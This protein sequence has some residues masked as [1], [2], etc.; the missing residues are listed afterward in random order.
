MAAWYYVACLLAICGIAA[1]A[2]PLDDFSNNLA[3]DLGPLLALFGEEATKQFLSESTTIWDNLNFAAAPIGILTAIVSAIRVCGPSWLRSFIGR[4]REGPEVAEV[5]LCSSTGRDVCEMYQNGVIMR[6]FGRP[7]LLEI[8][9]DPMADD[10]LTAGIYTFSEYR[11]TERGSTEWREQLPRNR[12]S[13]SEAESAEG[14]ERTRYAPNPNLML[15]IG[16][17]RLS[18]AVMIS[19]STFGVLVQLAA[20]FV[21]FAVTVIWPLQKDGEVSPHWALALTV[22]GTVL[23]CAGMFGCAYL[24]DESTTDRIFV[25]PKPSTGRDSHKRP[26]LYWVQPGG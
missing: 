16:Y 15:N 1:S 8:V 12:A 26:V 11:Q 14:F 17:R 3:T 5:E 22:T 6:A 2:D 21:A 4:A 24:I 25:R 10:G 7:K 9:H 19:V 20:I 13:A 23:L 18:T